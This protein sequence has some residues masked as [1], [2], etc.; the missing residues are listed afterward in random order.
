MRTLLLLLT[1]LLVAGCIAPKKVELMRFR[2]DNLLSIMEARDSVQLDSIRQLTTALNRAEGG[3]DALLRAQSGLE[4]KLVR[5]KDEL[6]ALKG[7]LSNTSARLSTELADSRAETKAALL[8]YDSLT[9]AQRA[10]VEDFQVRINRADTLLHDVLDTFFLPHNWQTSLRVGEITVSFQE[11]LLFERR[12]VDKLTE[13]SAI[14]LRAIVDVLQNDPLLKLTIVGHTDNQPS[15]RRNLSNWEYAALRATRLAD[16]LAETYYLSPNRLEAASHG[17][18]A[19]LTS[20]ATPE[21]Q[22]TNRR[23]DFVLRNNVGNLIRSLDKLNP[24]KR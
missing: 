24:E 3:N 12:S 15:P 22:A 18:F 16:Q 13:R 10:I 20:N 2:Y 1:P 5:Q 11:D 23:I 6:D 14:A 8:R 7:N 9:T 19:P 17:E 21:G 4:D